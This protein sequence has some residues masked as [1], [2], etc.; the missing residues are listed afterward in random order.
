MVELVKSHP[1]VSAIKK[2]RSKNL[3]KSYQFTPSASNQN[4]CPDHMKKLG[5]DEKHY[6]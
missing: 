5:F 3:L 2:L 1:I 4:P 6:K